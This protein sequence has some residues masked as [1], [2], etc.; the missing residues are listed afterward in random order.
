VLERRAILEASRAI[1]RTRGSG[2][3]CLLSR[4]EMRVDSDL[5]QTQM[6]G[7]DLGAETHAN[8]VDESLAYKKR[9]FL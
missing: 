6:L 2:I 7:E 3:D 9:D 8:D 4:S 1:N 5:L